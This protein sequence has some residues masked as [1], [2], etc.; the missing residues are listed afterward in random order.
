MY[1]DKAKETDSFFVAKDGTRL[2]IVTHWAPDPKAVILLWP[3]FGGNVHHNNMP[4]QR[5]VDKGYTVVFY[6]PR[7]HGRSADQICLPVVVAD[8][9]EFLIEGGFDRLPLIAVGHS[10]GS[11]GLLRLGMDQ[12][13]IQRLFL[14]APSFDPLDAIYHMYQTGAV[15]G[16][17]KM[18]AG[19]TEKNEL[20][21]EVLAQ[22]TWLEKDYWE[23]N[24][25]RQRLDA[26]PGSISIGRLLADQFF[27]DFNC[28]EDLYHQRNKAQI[29]LPI[30]DDWQPTERTLGLARKYDIPVTWMNAATEHSFNGAWPHVWEL[31]ERELSKS[32]PIFSKRA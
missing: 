13:N 30:R 10:I 18:L 29:I 4:I 5:F 22:P 8:L 32:P 23:A 26:L 25:L 21:K 28:Y 16:F 9:K 20:I 27:I 31:I 19:L 24:K 15:K 2:E 17:A 14:I 1:T 6:N 12:T 7:G 3:C 11:A